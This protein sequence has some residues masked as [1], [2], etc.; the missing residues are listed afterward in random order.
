[1][2]D[3]GAMRITGIRTRQVDVELPAPFHPAWA[4]GATETRIRLC[5]VRIETDAG[6]YG[7]AG[8]EFF[9]TEEQAVQ[10]IA[11]HL[12]GEDPLADREARR[13]APVPLALLRHRGLVRGAGA[14]G[15]PRQGG[16]PAGL[17][18]SRERPRRGGGLR[19]DRPEPDAGPAR[20]RL[21]AAAGRRVPGREAPDPQRHARRGPGSGEGG[22]EGGRRRDG[23]HGRRQPGRRRRRAPGRSA[24]ELPPGAP[25]R[26]GPGRVPGGLARGAA[27]PSRLRGVS[28]GSPRSRRRR[29][30]AARTT[31][32]STTCGVSW[33]TAATTSFSP[34]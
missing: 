8:H 9:G 3:R 32:S 16:R 7:V 17:Q 33:T 29:S 19:V 25:D 14:L 5:Y 28:G 23:H 15:H 20:R 6:V 10:R 13:H 22:P 1:M 24:L 12:V 4:P 21:P 2:G 18:A 11:T 34:T 26:A 27:A 30:P 31:S